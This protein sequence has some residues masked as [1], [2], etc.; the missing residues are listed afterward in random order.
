MK[1]L[2]VT[3]GTPVIEDSGGDWAMNYPMTVVAI[4]GSSGTLTIEYQIIADGSWTA[5]PSG[6]VSAKTVSI[7]DGPVYALRF[8]AYHVDGT[9]EIG[10]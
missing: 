5:W 2:T 4:P 3:V 9:V 8:T 10:S 6:T 7:L 1:S